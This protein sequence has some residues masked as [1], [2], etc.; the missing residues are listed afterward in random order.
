MHK[1][2]SLLTLL[3]IACNGSTNTPT[4]ASAS[5]KNNDQQVSESLNR[6]ESVVKSTNDMFEEISTKAKAG[7]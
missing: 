2:T 7:S 5:L 6:T 1:I 3:L 4:N